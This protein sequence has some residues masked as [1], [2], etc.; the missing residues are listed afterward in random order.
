MKIPLVTSV[1][2]F[3]VILLWSVASPAADDKEAI[4]A[5]VE[6]FL[7]DKPYLAVSIGITRAEG[8][9]VFGYGKV[10]LDGKEQTPAGDTLFEIGSITKVFTGALLAEQVRAGTMRLDDAVQKHLPEELAVPRRDDRD[11]TLLHLA[12]HTSSLPV[13]P[14]LIGFFALTTKDPK[15]PYAEFKEEN[16]KQTLSTMKLTR[17]LGSQFEYSNL[18]VGIL[19]H[20]VA[21]AAK[22][23][24]YEELLVERLATPLDMKDTRLALSPEHQLRFAPG[25]TTD[26]KPTSP[27]TFACLEACGGLR[28]TATDML[29]FID[30]NLGRKKSPLLE[31]FQFAHQPW[32]E[33]GQ[34]GQHIGL[35]WMRQKIPAR[36]RTMIW[37]NGGTGGYRSFAGF[38]P[39]SG[40]GVVVLSN[41]PH[42]VDPLGVS[43]LKHLD[44]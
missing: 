2:A 16:L 26:G 13:Q 7:K 25:Q 27:W 17:P 9:Q 14:P 8:Q 11:I 3:V 32:R 30:A 22:A 15:N 42:S 20:A 39:E 28:S 41:S 1:G 4:D 37:H 35:C 34:P 29:S 31:A 10:T 40:V 12:T 5:L 19:G 6:P 33:L 44:K 43:I 21:R 23:K 36:S 38:L 24:S 18:G